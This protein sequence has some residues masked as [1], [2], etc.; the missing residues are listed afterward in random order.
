MSVSDTDVGAIYTG[1]GSNVNFP[2]VFDYSLPAQVK[3]FAIVISTGVIENK[4][5]ATDYTIS[6]G[7][8]V[9]GTAPPATRYLVVERSSAF[10]QTYDFDNNTAPF[11]EQ[12]EAGLDELLRK[13]QENKD[14]LDRTPSFDRR[15]DLSSF[16]LRLPPDWP[17]T[18]GAVLIINDAGTGFATGP[19]ADEISGA[20][21]AAA[22]AAA[23]QASAT[24]SQAAATASQV[25]AAASQASATASQAAAAASAA[26][27]AAFAN[28]VLGSFAAGVSV[29]NAAGFADAESNFDTTAGQQTIFFE[30]E[31]PGINTISVDPAIEAHTVEGA[32][33]RLVDSG[34]GVNFLRLVDDSLILLKGE[35]QSEGNGDSITLI[36]SAGT[37]RELAR[38]T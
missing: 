28:V 31:N 10:T 32:I 8:V 38:N 17:T 16:D 30:A 6:G 3:V 35:W 11:S 5:L 34:G 25:A 7:N 18:P 9:M 19:T 4:V 15:A 23:A 20:A 36:W 2:I 24:A 26:S 13:S 37:Y 14:R 22:A 33:V 12:L 29:L 21:D 1:N 27:A